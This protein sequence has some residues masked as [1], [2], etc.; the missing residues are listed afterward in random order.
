MG[1]ILEA[2]E[3]AEARQAQKAMQ[4]GGTLLGFFWIIVST[5]HSTAL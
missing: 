3:D 2:K 1:K 5:I 4:D